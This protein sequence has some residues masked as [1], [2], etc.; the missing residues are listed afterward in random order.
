[1]DSY[2]RP[3]WAEIDLEALR[4]NVRA[5][6][7][8]LAP[9]VR[10]MAVVKADGYGHGAVAV[11]KAALEA[12]ADCLGVALIEE[13]AELRADGV[14]APIQ[15]LSEMPDT[16]AGAA[17]ELGVIATVCSSGAARALSEA[18]SMAGKTVACHLKVDTGMNRLG[19]KPGEALGLAEEVAGRPGLA[20]DG[21][22]THF[23]CADQPDDVSVAT[24]T[25]LFEQVCG[26]LERRGLAGFTRHAANSAAA[27]LV[28]RTHFD[29]VR[30]GI[31]IYGLHPGEATKGRVKL[32]PAMSL[33]SRL[34]FVKEVAAGEGVS[35]GHIH[36]TPRAT[37][38][39]TVP[40]GYADGYTRLLSGKSEVLVGGRR[41]PVIGRVCMDQF[42]V[43]LG[44]EGDLR[45]GAEVVRLGRQG[46][47]EITA[48]ELAGLIGTINYEIVCMV[49]KRVP[50]VYLDA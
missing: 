2:R 14:S 22:F 42:M 1:M 41:A 49:S 9:G 38:I 10:V 31:S 47:Q 25:E 43:D 26:E 37:V 28:P 36:R 50:R 15:V 27:V 45:S 23:A 48:D 11:A 33:K 6:D 32:K 19:A 35:Y 29:M 13:A 7:A 40:A 16:A 30:L 39:G 17:V 5:I 34:S 20:L 12:G 24:Q 44:P 18:A 21:V 8:L 3:V 4:H 46:D